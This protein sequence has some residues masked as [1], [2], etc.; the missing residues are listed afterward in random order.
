MMA[1]TLYVA[2][3]VLGVVAVIIGPALYAIS[4]SFFNWQP[5]GSSPFVGLANYTSLA[6]SASFR[7]ILVNEGIYLLGLPFWTFLPP[8]IAVFL[9]TKVRVAGAVRTLIFLPAIISPALL[10]VMFS[11]I[12]SP[13]GLLDTTLAKVGLGRAGPALARKPRPREADH[14]R[15]SG[16]G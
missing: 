12:L 9:F 4:Q 5:G 13:T 11:P 2:P 1:T 14:H 8:I 16:V 7:E 15:Y 3:L 10:G 6:Q